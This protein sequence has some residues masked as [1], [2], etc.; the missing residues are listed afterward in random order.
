MAIR[1]LYFDEAGFTGYNLLDPIQPVFAIASADI[2]EDEAESVLKDSFPRYRAD[3]YKFKNIWGSS[4]QNGFLQFAEHLAN[5][6]DRM[7]IYMADKRFTVLTKIVDFLIEPSVTAAGY[8]FYSDGFCWKYANYIHYGMTNYARPEML[9]R[10]LSIYQTFSRTPSRGNLAAL[11]KQL[12]SMAEGAGQP[13]QIFLEQMAF[14]AEH[15]EAYHDLDGFRGSDDLQFTTMLAIVSYWRQQFD[16][17][18]AVFHDDSSNFLRRRDMWEKVTSPKVPPQFHGS[19]DGSFIRYPLR[20]ISTTP[21]NSRVSFSIQVCDLLAGL[22]TKHFSTHTEG[23]D[24]EFMDRVISAGLM[25][26][27]YNG[28]RPSTIFPDYFPPRRLTGP[29]VVD[30]MAGILFRPNSQDT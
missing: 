27:T 5:I 4:N 7:F 22:A 21:L 14:G 12:R 30:Q 6:S 18:F 3:E 29:D 1:N 24:R 13:N 8:D 25:N 19:G 23:A 11:Q 2:T 15:F 9:A 17:D 16:D 10:L 28:L 26:I 20:V